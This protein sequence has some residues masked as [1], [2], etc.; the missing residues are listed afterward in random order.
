MLAQVHRCCVRAFSARIICDPS[1]TM[2]AQV[3]R[4]GSYA[5]F[6]R[7]RTT[8]ETRDLRLTQARCPQRGA[9]RDLMK[10]V[11]LAP[12]VVCSCLLVVAILP[13]SVPALLPLPSHVKF[14]D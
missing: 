3:H 7:G 2:L 14:V 12:T 10:K 9:L 11:V 1:S 4:C 13:Q 5:S 6:L 8:I